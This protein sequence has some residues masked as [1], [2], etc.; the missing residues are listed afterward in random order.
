ME[1][2]LDHYFWLIDRL[3]LQDNPKN[4]VNKDR[5]TVTLD[6]AMTNS[7]ANGYYVGKLVA[8]IYHTYIKR[9]G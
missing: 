9:S 6:F 8:E 2:N 3:D 7:F 1:L 5:N 4:T